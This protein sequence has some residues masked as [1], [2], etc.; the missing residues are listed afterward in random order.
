MASFQLLRDQILD[1]FC[2]QLLDI[3]PQKIKHI[4]RSKRIIYPFIQWEE[5]IT[6]KTLYSSKKDMKKIKNMVP[7]LK[8]L[9]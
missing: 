1:C 6:P 2:L 8:K 5:F 4:P 3:N 9:I 7:D